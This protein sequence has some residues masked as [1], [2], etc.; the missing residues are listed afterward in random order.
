MKPAGFELKF[1]NCP[2]PVCLGRDN[3]D[4]MGQK[5]YLTQLKRCFLCRQAKQRRCFVRKKLLF[6]LGISRLFWNECFP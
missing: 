3:A 1:E 4:F 5:Q 6:P 2:L